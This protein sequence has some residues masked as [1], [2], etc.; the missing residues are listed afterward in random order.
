LRIAKRDKEETEY[1]QA[2]IQ[3]FGISQMGDT[4]GILFFAFFTLAPR[5]FCLK[6]LFV[7]KL[8]L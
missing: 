2:R 3:E 1:P 6:W 5:A 4:M 7:R 8:A